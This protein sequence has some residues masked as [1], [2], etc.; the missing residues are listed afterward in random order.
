MKI[1]RTKILGFTCV[2]ILFSS[3]FCSFLLPYLPLKLKKAN[4]ELDLPISA[5]IYFNG[6]AELAANASSGYGNQ[7][8]PYII[9]DI[10]IDDSDR[11]QI[12]NTDAHFILRNCSVIGTFMA[13]GI[14]FNNVTN[15]QIENNT[16]M[17]RFDGCIDI[18]HSSKILI[19]NCTILDSGNHGIRFYNV[20]NGLI[21]NNTISNCG[22]GIYL[23][24][25]SHN[26]ILNNSITRANHLIYLNM[27]SMNNTIDDNFLSNTGGTD[28]GKAV[29]FEMGCINNTVLNN[30]ISNEANSSKDIGVMVF[31]AERNNIIN[32]S[33]NDFQVGVKLVAGYNATIENNNISNNINGISLLYSDF[34]NI[35][36][37]NIY[38][39]TEHA[40]TGEESDN[41]TIEYNQVKN[42]SKEGIFCLFSNDS[43]IR[44]NNLTYNSWAGVNLTVCS[45]S[46]VYSNDFYGNYLS[47]VQGHD[48]DGDNNSWDK[49]NIGNYWDDYSSR[50]PTANQVG[51]YWDVPYNISGNSFAQDRFPQIKSTLIQNFY[52]PNLTSGSVEPTSGNQSVLFNF[53]VNFTDSDNNEPISIDVFMNGTPFAMEK[54]NLTDYNYTD[55]CTYQFLTYLQPGDYNYSFNCSDGEF[56]NWTQTYTGFTVD[57]TNDLTPYLQAPQVNPEIERNS[58]IYNF[59]VEYFDDD[60]NFPSSINITINSTEFSMEVANFSDTNCMDGKK[61]YYNTTLDYGYY[62]FQ[63]NC[64]DGSNEN[65]T[66][67][68]YKPEV[69]PFYGLLDN[70]TLLTLYNNSVSFP[71]EINFTWESLELPNV[72]L[73]YTLQI[74]NSSDF[75]EII[76]EITQIQESTVNTTQNVTMDLTYT[77]YFWRCR[78]NFENFIGNWSD[79]FILNIVTNDFSPN[80]TDDSVSPLSGDQFTLFNF[81]VTYTDQ[82]NNT[83]S[84]VNVKINETSYEMT[85]SNLSDHDYADGSFYNY[86]TLL[87]PGFFN[88]SFECNDGKFANSTITYDGFEVI[89]SNN[90]PFLLNTSVTPEIGGNTAIYAFTTNYYDM[91]NE[92]PAYVNIT[93]NSTTY[94]MLPVDPFDTNAT[95]GILYNY[96]TTLGYGYYSFQINVSDGYDSNST[97]WINAPISSPFYDATIITGEDRIAINEICSNPDFVELYN[98]GSDRDMTGWTIQIYHNS[99]L[100]NTY[101]FPNGWIFKENYVV[102]L[103]ENSGTNTDTVLYTGWNIPWVSSSAVAVGLF[104]NGAHVDWVQTSSFSGSKPGDVEWTQDRTLSI[105]DYIYRTDDDDTNCATDW[106]YGG[107]G[108]QGSLNPG[109]TGVGGG[110]GS[111]VTILELVSPLNES[112]HFTGEINFIWSSPVYSLGPVNYMLQVSNVSDFS[113]IYY[114]I[115][116][117]PEATYRTN[118]TL[119]IDFSV[120]NTYYWRVCPIYASIRG[121]WTESFVIYNETNDYCPYLISPQVS[122]ELGGILSIFNFT[123]WY[124]DV[125]NNSPA[126]INIRINSSSYPMLQANP[127]DTNFVDGALFYYST[128]LNTL[129]NYQF[130]INCSDGH[131]LNSTEWVLFPTVELFYDACQHIVINELSTGNTD[132]IEL[133][134]YGPDTD[135]TGWYVRIYNDNSLFTTYNFPNGWIFKENTVVVLHEG[136]G[137]NSDTDLYIS[138]NIPWTGYGIAV[139]LFDDGANNI[140]WFQTSSYTNVIPSDAEWVLDVPLTLDNNYACRIGD[141]DSNLSSNWIVLS[142]GSPNSLNFWQIE[143]GHYASAFIN[144]EEQF[145]YSPGM[146]HITWTSMGIPLD[147]LC[148]T[149]Q[150][151]ATPDFSS[152]LYELDNIIENSSIISIL[153]Q[154][155]LNPGQF[156]CRIRPYSGSYYG[157][158]TESSILTVAGSSTSNFFDVFILYLFSF[159]LV[160]AIISSLILFSRKKLKSCEEISS[161]DKSKMGESNTTESADNEIKKSWRNSD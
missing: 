145:H 38:N 147:S 54:Q 9:E 93:I 2:F 85:K 124:F 113:Q 161:L 3:F 128:Q 15:G 25:S 129:G 5:S 24:Y 64:S 4:S 101:T 35:K 8:H 92:T 51:N 80:L 148:Y 12:E 39:N 105:S 139:G 122:P 67:W 152:I 127:F 95:D 157:N 69:N 91:D 99:V 50:Y 102:V 133:Y 46:Q 158:W 119:F 57:S 18:I 98:Y 71:G 11:I 144:I 37:N 103:R 114:Q 149:F 96:S 21:K 112:L 17:N 86:S 83:P 10:Y 63:V 126:W 150:I 59:T 159:G 6:N 74:S 73:N 146:F 20:S 72:N 40:I 30:V 151:S 130:Q 16:I 48:M 88:Y 143:N 19:N 94:Q 49:N 134:N 117:I 42:N 100:D 28:T 140:D 13:Y 14:T 1:K 58:T 136:S 125:D 107:S 52:S 120:N 109:Q 7:S 137:T 115:E 118:K 106:T 65:G 76:H 121:N 56:F 84:F 77:E 47:G 153:I 70:I 26:I 116:N 132:Y 53:T 36:R 23:Y 75:T 33:I 43:I 131:R 79:Y 60:N 104:D 31:T 90:I 87:T 62:K 44:F 55:G 29:N 66:S 89:N 61:Y 141:M 108:T 111:N 82:D 97:G 156:Y 160:G 138:G 81:N 135:M 123:T 154:L 142:F 110:G 45:N 22:R 155:N 41:I 27:N 32:N 68:I 34:L 78:P